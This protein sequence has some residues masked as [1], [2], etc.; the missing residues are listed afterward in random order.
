VMLLPYYVASMNIER[1]YYD[2]T[3]KYESFP[4]I[5]LVDTFETVEKEEPEFEIFSEETLLGSHASA[6]RPSKSSSPIRLTT[7]GK[8]TRMTTTR[9]ASIPKSTDASVLHTAPIRKRRSCV[10]SA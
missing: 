1:A 9:T 6:Q 3:G 2:V 4:G 7:R 5:C 8:S 10:N